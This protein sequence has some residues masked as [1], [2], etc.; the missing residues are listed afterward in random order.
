MVK[1]HDRFPFNLVVLVGDNLYGS[2]RPQDFVKKF[3][4]PYQALL[5]RRR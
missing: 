1:L 4:Q 3:E 2:R 5:E